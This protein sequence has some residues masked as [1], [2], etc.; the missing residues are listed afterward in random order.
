[1]SSSDVTDE[2]QAVET[3]ADREALAA[4]IEVLTEENRRLRTEYRRA[5]Q[6]RHR[7]TALGLAG[8][9]LAALFGAVLFSGVRDVLLALSGTGLFAAVLVR[10]LT[11]ERFIAASVGERIYEA[12]ATTGT[13]LIA[14]LGLTTEHVYVPAEETARLFVPQYQ[15][16][17]LPDEDA[18]D[19]MFVVTDDQRRGVVL[20]PTGSGLF[21]EFK[22]DLSDAPASDPGALSEQLTDALV[23]GFEIVD[24]ARAD[25]EPGRL[26]VALDG[27]VYGAVD[28]FDHPI[29]S[30]LAVGVAATLGRA[31]SLEITQETDDRADALVTCRWE[32]DE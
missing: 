6:T 22:R 1:M 3:T 7:E 13:Q 10:T 8:L 31:V 27:P 2:E 23:D 4:Q 11:P 32:T 19:G 15:S 30:F 20:E 5:R 18:L 21:Q 14:D 29:P 17:D 25:T 12:Y 16:Y 26:S 9:G 24:E 28:G